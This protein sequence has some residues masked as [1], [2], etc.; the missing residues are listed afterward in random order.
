MELKIGRNVGGSAAGTEVDQC[1]HLWF[2]ESKYVILS[3]FLHGSINTQIHYTL[4]LRLV[5]PL[6]TMY[7]VTTLDCN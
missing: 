7:I 5:Y 2:N 6:L 1:T 4:V 3:A